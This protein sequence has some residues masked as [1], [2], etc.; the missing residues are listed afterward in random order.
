MTS[1]STGM[2][3]V[4]AVSRLK[5][6]LLGFAGVVIVAA[7][8][9][10][11]KDD[12]AIATPAPLFLIPVLLAGFFGGRAASATVAGVATLVY[13]LEFIP[14]LGSLHVPLAE[15]V[16]SIVFFLVVALT[17][18]TFIARESEAR[19]VAIAR[20]DELAITHQRLEATMRERDALEAET[21][22]I[23]VLEEVDRQRTAMLRA[24]SHDLRTPLSTIRAAAGELH[25]DIGF[26][27]DERCELAGLVVTEAER[28]DRI[29]ANLLML[30]RAEAGAMAVQLGAIDLG[31]VIARC[32][33]RLASLLDGLAVTV[34]LPSERLLIMGDDVLLDQIFTNLF[35]NVVR[36]ARTATQ[37]RITGTAVGER[38][39]IT[40]EDNGRGLRHL[41]EVDEALF[42]PFTP[43]ATTAGTG[44]GLAV[45]RALAEGCGGTIVADADA[46]TGAR[47][48]LEFR[49]ASP[50]HPD[51]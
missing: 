44:L 28:L 19:R 13:W 7:A 45:C 39:C 11:F 9:N 51:R 12:L 33:A 42:V 16:V 2:R 21:R 29:V 22:R 48:E 38:A 14:P 15:D 24:V 49:L 43:A 41:T 20:A 23:A 5:G 27:V 31:E 8:L 50:E 6:F 30:S 10:P 18:G 3:N 32:H 1:A 47:F 46:D 34:E 40:F 26:S 37:I 35:E 25:S 17:T 36:H 4:L